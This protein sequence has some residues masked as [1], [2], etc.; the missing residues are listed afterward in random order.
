[1]FAHSNDS[2]EKQMD[3]GN[4][5]SYKDIKFNILV[6]NETKKLAIIGEVQFILRWMLE[7]KKMSHLVYSF[8]RKRQWIEN[9]VKMKTVQQNQVVKSDSN[10][11]KKMIG[12][13]D[14]NKFLFIILYNFENIVLNN[15]N[16][17][18]NGLVSQVFAPNWDNGLKIMFGTLVH[19]MNKY[20][21]LSNK[22]KYAKLVE[23]INDQQL[24]NDAKLQVMKKQLSPHQ[25]HFLTNLQNMNVLNDANVKLT[26]CGFFLCFKFI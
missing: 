14:L 3:N 9:V 4:E 20:K 19:Y 2:D 1:M 8:V 7:A 17:S 21:Q 6:E 24:W 23:W 26:L 22:T 25:M 15:N 11:I 10:L 16:S 5:Y 13:K 12:F 18:N